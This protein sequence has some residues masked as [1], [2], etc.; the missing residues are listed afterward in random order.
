MHR[1]WEW[2]DTA[3][4]LW[5]GLS[6]QEETCSDRN[7]FHNVLSIPCVF[8]HPRLLHTPAWALARS[9]RSAGTTPLD[10]Q[11][12]EPKLHIF[13]LGEWVSYP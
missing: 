13:L 6:S 11:N 1:G 12:Y 2:T 4:F 7:D 9:S 8:T 10:L 3:A 5:S